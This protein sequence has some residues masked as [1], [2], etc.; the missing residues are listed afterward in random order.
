MLMHV[1]RGNAPNFDLVD[2]IVATFNVSLTVALERYVATTGEPCVLVHSREGYIQR[3]S[4]SRD[5]KE[6]G[7][8]VPV[9]TRVDP[10]TYAHSAFAGESVP[11]RGELV[12]ASSWFSPG[13]YRRDAMVREFTWPMPRFQSALSLVWVHEDMDPE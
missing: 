3:F 13:R 2:E 9:R 5:F 10:Y 4:P 1:T 7:L 11:R 8:Y 12:D 6:M